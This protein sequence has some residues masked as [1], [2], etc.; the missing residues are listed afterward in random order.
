MP[1]GGEPPKDNYRWWVLVTVV[2]GAFASILDSTIVNTA[3][4][5]IQHDF[6]A[7][8]HLASYVATGYILA[9]GVVVPASGFLANRFG[10]KRVYTTSL[11]LF[12]LGSALCGAAPNIH[13]LIAA[14]VL[15]GAGGAAL[16]PLGFALLFSVFSNEERGKANGIFGIPVLAAPALG[17]TLGGYLTEYVD[18]RWVFYVNLP[19]GILGV[20]MCL[21]I[22]RKSPMRA[23]LRF[24][25]PGFVL[26]SSGLGLLLFGLSNLAYD[27]WNSTST[28]S[29]PIVV[30]VLLLVGFVV[31]ALWSK[32]P[33]LQLRLYRRRNYT[34][35]TLII[36]V[37]TVGL[38]G[39]GFLLPQYLQGLRDQTPFAAGLLLLWGG[40]GAVGGSVASGQLYNRLGPKLLVLV[41]LIILT[42]TSLLLTLWTTV[43]SELNLLIPIMLVRGFGLPLMLQ[44]VNTMALDG[45][46]GPEL[47]DATTL[48]V[49]TRNVIGSLSIALLTNYLYD[50]AATHARDL[51]RTACGHIGPIAVGG[52]PGS[53][54][55]AIIRQAVANA[56]QDT[57]VIVT[58]L[59]LPAFLLAWQLR[60]PAWSLGGRGAGAGPAENATGAEQ[61]APSPAG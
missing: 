36:L 39:P 4:P 15:Q 11:V 55:P 53:A 60:K 18:W 44:S 22:L 24:D 29:G 27:G 31:E 45:I 1:N 8:L 42:I 37:G 58:I 17:P 20:V 35:G 41:G 21:R 33:L 54:M 61:E 9:A 12:T 25:L 47:P 38:F 3:L 56:Y 13:L 34:L 26:A 10:I 40:I 49:V 59:V 7:D 32:A 6:G 23:N 5:R 50:R 52:V 43:D 2:F 46:R 51:C 57:Y 28:V 48:S 14:R 19:I 16:F 30:S